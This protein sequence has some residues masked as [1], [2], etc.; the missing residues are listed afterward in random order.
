M[1]PKQI[2]S[3]SNAIIKEAARLKRKR[4]RYQG[5]LFLAEGE[6]L[7][8]SALERGLTPRQVFVLQGYEELPACQAVMAG[9]PKRPGPVVPP[10]EAYVCSQAVMEKLS[11]LGSGSRVISVFEMLDRK[12]PAGL[13]EPGAAG[14]GEPGGSDE[15]GAPGSAELP[16]GPLLYLAGAGDPGNVGTLLRSVAALGAQAVVLGPETA[17]PYSAKSL[18]ATMGAIFQV[19]FFLT[20][21]PE[22]LVSWADRAGA[23]IICADAHAGEPAW[24]APLAGRFVLVMGPER[25]GIQRRLLDAAQATVRIP[26]T[27]AAESLNV[28]MAATA[29]LYEALRQRAGAGSAGSGGSAGG[30]S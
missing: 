10:L 1:Q 30:A 8:E 7:L 21:N 22:T 28:A 19:P 14:G 13:D 9:Q 11:Q 23:A 3:T 6:D 17:D 2:T 26:Q 29:I 18:R 20:V 15:P 25:Q 12:F 4:N 27:E 5:R 16:A 24:Q